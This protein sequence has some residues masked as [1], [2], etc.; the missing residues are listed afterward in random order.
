MKNLRLLNY[1]WREWI[2]ININNGVDKDNIFNILLNHNFE[3]DEIAKEMNYNP[4]NIN[5][6]ERRDAQKNKIINNKNK[7][8]NI[9]ILLD[10]HNVYKIENDFLEIYKYPNFLTNDECDNLIFDMRDNFIKSTITNKNEE[11]NFRTSSSCHIKSTTKL[12]NEINKR[13]HNLL[14]IPKEYGESL[15]GQ[16]Y[17]I[18]QE[19]KEHTDYFDK[20]MYY[21]EEFLSNGGQRTWT[22]MIYLNDVE[23]GGETEFRKINT[24]FKPVKGMAL[25]WNNLQ[26][27]EIENIYSMHCGLPIKKG[28]KYIIT[29]WFRKNTIVE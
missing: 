2:V 26:N 15:Q 23:D 24:K 13:I 14:N 10:N 28:K 5:I 9:K 25:I 19:F 11:K 18:G 4:I 29:K 12:F 6:I 21:N 16:K 27:D 3:Y 17:E 8:E 20:G 1:K 7:F 22:V